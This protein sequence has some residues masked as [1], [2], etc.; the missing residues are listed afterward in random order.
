M[1]K[2]GIELTLLSY[3]RHH[4]HC[5]HTTLIQQKRRDQDFVGMQRKV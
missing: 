2:C 4:R 3:R 1:R 5:R